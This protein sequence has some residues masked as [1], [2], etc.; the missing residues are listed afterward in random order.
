[1]DPVRMVSMG[2][3]SRE[4]CGGTHLNNT[5]EVGPFEVVSEE[6]VSAGVRR[7]V[8]LTGE[9]AAEFRKKTEA[10]LGQLATQ[11]KVT[12][13]QIP[14]AVKQMTDYVRDLKKAVN[15]G[16]NPPEAPKPTA[17]KQGE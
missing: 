1:P 11:L 9:K 12:E 13:E 14:A 8:A 5:S 16:G 15:G 3:F 7:I 10:A 6:G 2:E 4:L 17:A